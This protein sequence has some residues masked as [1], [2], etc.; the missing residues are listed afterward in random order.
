MHGMQPHRHSK[1]NDSA[2]QLSDNICLR[3]DTSLKVLVVAQAAWTQDW[4][5][6][7]DEVTQDFGLL[8]VMPKT[9]FHGRGMMCNGKQHGSQKLL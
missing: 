8:P 2:A 6:Q 3:C 7:L 5:G 4:T 1:A 9:P